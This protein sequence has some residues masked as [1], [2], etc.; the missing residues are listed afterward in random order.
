[1]YPCRVCLPLLIKS[2]GSQFLGM[3]ASKHH[4]RYR[5]FPSRPSLITPAPPPRS[6]IFQHLPNFTLHP[7]AITHTPSAPMKT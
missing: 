3:D 6:Y 7:M 4:Q 5:S 2:F 1:M